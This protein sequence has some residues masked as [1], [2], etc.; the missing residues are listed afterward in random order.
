MLAVARVQTPSAPSIWCCH[1]WCLGHKR[2]AYVP[3]KSNVHTIW[4]PG[5]MERRSGS[6]WP[7]WLEHFRPPALFI[8]SAT[9]DHSVTGMA[10]SSVCRNLFSWNEV[11]LLGT[12]A[13]FACCH[14]VLLLVCIVLFYLSGWALWNYC[15]F[16]RP[17]FTANCLDPGVKIKVHCCQAQSLGNPGLCV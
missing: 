5:V 16:W 12:K 11:A 3:E 10:S 15:T 9:D 6:W 4:H 7:P 13:N 17:A 8:I 14:F 2:V 1:A